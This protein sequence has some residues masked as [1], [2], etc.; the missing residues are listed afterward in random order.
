MR[1][2]VRGGGVNC[3]KGLSLPDINLGV[4]INAILSTRDLMTTVMA[5][6][7]QLWTFPAS[8]AAVTLRQAGRLCHPLH[9][10]QSEE[11]AN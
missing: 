2:G 10:P 5:D 4:I 9:S 11:R 1:G 8:S 3:N 6:F 7:W